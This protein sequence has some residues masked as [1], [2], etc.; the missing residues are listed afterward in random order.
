L[1]ALEITA[2]NEGFA[3]VTLRA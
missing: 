3:D 2:A 1:Q